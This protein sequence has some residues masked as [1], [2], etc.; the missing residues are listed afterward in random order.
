MDI[1]EIRIANLNRLLREFDGSR[2]EFAKLCGYDGVNYFNQL[3]SGHGSFGNRTAKKISHAL[4]RDGGFLDRTQSNVEPAIAKPNKAPLISNVQA[5]VWM[6][7]ID[8]F[9]TNDAEEWLPRPVG[10]E[11]SYY[12]RVVGDSMSSTSG[13]SFPEGV[14][15]LIDPDS[16]WNN[17]D[18]VVA[19]I[20]GEN[21]V[22]FK[23]LKYDE[24]NRPYLKPLNSQWPDIFDEFRIL[25]KMVFSGNFY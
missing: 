2:E 16:Q 23:Q 5:G 11:R 21:G 22:T 1:K 20:N 15:V 14:L 17:G 9:A 6:E 8:N 12:L 13:V 24:H 18:Y 25:G 7:G 3:L 4:N 10:G 19:K